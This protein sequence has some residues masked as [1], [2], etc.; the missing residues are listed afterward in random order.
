[1]CCDGTLFHCVTLQPNDSPRALTSLG[2]KVKRRRDQFTFQQPCP[3]HRDCNC[4]IYGSRP[5]RCRD[6]HCRQ[7][8]KLAANELTESDVHTAIERAQ[9][10]TREVKE[11]LAQIAPTNPRRSL[12]Q[13]V[14][15]AL[16][17]DSPT[18]AQVA[19]R[20]A[21]K[22]LEITLDRDFRVADDGHPR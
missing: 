20:A 15:N 5:T 4:Q 13:R 18:P 2:L 22:R 10:E 12:A 21:F 6:F 9:R 1:M 17:T 14:A 16:T 19:L 3:A 11:L 7:L 8:L